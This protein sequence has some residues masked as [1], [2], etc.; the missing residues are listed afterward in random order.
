V[1]AVCRAIIERDI[2]GPSGNQVRVEAF[3]HG[4]LCMAISGKCYLSLHEKN[5][6]AN[7]GECMQLCRRAYTV[8][9][10]EDNYQLEIDNEY[11]MSP[12][13]LSTIT[14]IDQLLEAG[15]RILKI[16]GRSRPPEYVK[17][18]TSCYRDAIDHWLAGA[19]TVEKAKEW[20]EKLSSVFNRGFWEGYYMGKNS[21]EWSK[22][23]G[24]NATH[25]KVYVGKGINY[26]ARIGVAEFKIETNT[27][28]KGDRILI[29]G[30][31]TG[32][33]ETTVNEI[34]VNLKPVSEAVKGEH[35]SIPVP[36]MV[37]RSDKLYKIVSADR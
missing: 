27:I 3:A 13:D 10:K 6:S 4:A 19:F 30:P 33:V 8:F 28:K 37:R 35:F 7:R 18:T 2:R 24:S 12:K 14:F 15:V 29:M 5:K 32:V 34:R 20:E 22:K 17:T 11:I 31:T 16:E 1:Q 23:Y 21:G 36:E 25:R 9:E 26:F